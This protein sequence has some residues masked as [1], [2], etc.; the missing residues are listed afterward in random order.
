MVEGQ[1][2]ETLVW[3]TIFKEENLY[4]LLFSIFSELSGNNVQENYN[5]RFFEKL[6]QIEFSSSVNEKLNLN[7]S[8]FEEME[9]LAIF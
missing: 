1:I 5:F 6:F 9:F 3:T 2:I 7:H 4:K 8:N